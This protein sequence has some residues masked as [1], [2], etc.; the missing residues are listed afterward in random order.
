MKEAGGDVIGLDWR[1]ES[2]ARPGTG[3][4]AKV[5]VQGN[6]DPAHS[7][8]PGARDSPRRG[9]ILVG[10]AR[11]PGHIFNLGH[12]RAIRRRPWTTMRALV[13]MV[14]EM[15]ARYR[16]SPCDSSSSAAASRLSARI[17][18]GGARA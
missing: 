2:S 15:S 6:L 5:A 9:A 17:G 4:W 10:A 1:V 12:R 18:G 3:W 7:C 16:V 13:D 11:R 8:C 14:H